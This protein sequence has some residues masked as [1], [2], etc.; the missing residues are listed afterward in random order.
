[1]RPRERDDR[2]QQLLGLGDSGPLDLTTLTE[3]QLEDVKS[4]RVF[5]EAVERAVR[6]TSN[7]TSARGLDW[8]I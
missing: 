2:I 7:E 4:F 1:M 6:G 3:E 8:E 5:A